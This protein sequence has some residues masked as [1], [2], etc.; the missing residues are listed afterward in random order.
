[1]AVQVARL[2]LRLFPDPTRVITRLFC[3]A[4]PDRVRGL[5][6]RVL[7]IP[8]EE[9][10]RLLEGLRRD[11]RIQHPNLLDLFE[12]HYREV[13]RLV[14]DDLP[15]PCGVHR[16][17]IGAYF[18]MEYALES[19][20]L[21]NPSIVPGMDQSGVPPGGVRFLIS[22]RAVGEGHVSSIVFRRG[23]I[24]P[25]GQ[26]DI[27]PV[28]SVSRPLKAIE[29]T[30]LLK[31]DFRRELQALGA[32]HGDVDAVFDSLG[33]RFTT[34]DLSRAIAATREH[35]A[36]TGLFE[37]SCE[38]LLTLAHSS[39]DLLLPEDLLE[40][41]I[42]IFPQA[43]HEWHGIEDLRLVRFLDDDGTTRYYGTYTAYDGNRV[44]PQLMEYRGARIVRIT[45]IKGRCAR[46]K[47]MAL[48]PRKIRGHYAMV[49]R[50]DNENLF[51]MESDDVRYWD[52]A[53]PLQVPTFPWDLV[54]IGNCGSPIETEA[55]WL[56]LTHGVGP[57]RRYSIGASLLDLDDPSRV[58]GQ[59]PEPLLVPSVDE[60]AG[61]VPNVVYSCG[62]MIH[63]GRLILPYALNDSS[64][65]FATIELDELLASL[66][67]P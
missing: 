18:T 55:G 6:R 37:R 39:Y 67:R 47:G 9:S 38:A 12:E 1:M 52:D 62:G 53:R 7:A 3:P 43:D 15:D 50:L 36:P 10:E 27:D 32:E 8:E 59:T 20:A 21:F 61:Y 63:A 33:E 64:T 35:L 31:V 26:V 28:P 58:I 41:E 22:L 42:V 14:P 57:M 44:Y 66:H 5:V 4:D 54:Q 34:D 46:N 51:Y 25:G 65:A 16:S 2:S 29:P 11:F 40:S 49:S 17:L 30:K 48:F 23:L 13:R 19:V 45:M 60:R 24:G 56:L